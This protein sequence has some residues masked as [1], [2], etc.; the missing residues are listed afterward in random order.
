MV[1]TRF[2]IDVDSC[3]VG[4]RAGFIERAD[5][6]MFIIV[7]EVDAS[8][9]DVAAFDYNGT[10]HWIWTHLSATFGGETKGFLHVFGIVHNFLTTKNTK[11]TKFIFKIFVL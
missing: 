3:A 9:N 1:A 11:N 5:L 8:T 4:C 6:A 2:E 10:D 7:E